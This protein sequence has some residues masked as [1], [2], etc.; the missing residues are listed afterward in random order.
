MLVSIYLPESTLSILRYYGDVDKVVNKILEEFYTRQIDFQ[1]APSGVPRTYCKRVSI[2]ITYKPY[3]ED[4]EVTGIKNKSLS[5]SRIVQLFIDGGYYNEFGW[6]MCTK[7]PD[8]AAIY[9]RII[10]LENNSKFLVKNNAKYADELM[11]LLE[12][13]RLLYE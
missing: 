6:K 5:L 7:N 11:K 10:F 1:N 4:V 3:I 13:M 12:K 8:N 9:K 2:N